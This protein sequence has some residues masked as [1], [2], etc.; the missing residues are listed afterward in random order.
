MPQVASEEGRKKKSRQRRLQKR[1]KTLKS[2]SEV[3]I[4]FNQPYTASDLLRK[5]FQI[6]IFVAMFS[7]PIKKL[8]LQ[9]TDLI[10]V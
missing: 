8:F 10:R 6:F 4:N 9:P 3:S 5:I 7:I 1:K 2:Q